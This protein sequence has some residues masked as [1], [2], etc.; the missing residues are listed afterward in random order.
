MIAFAKMLQAMALGAALS[1]AATAAQAADPIK[2]GF[3]TSLTGGNAAFGRAD[4]VTRQ[5][6]AE[7]VNAKGGL[8]GRPVK[9][10]YYDDQSTPANAPSIYTKL[11][12]VDKVDLLTTTG[13]NVTAAAMPSLVQHNRLVMSLFSLAVNDVFKYP[14]YFQIMT[15]GPHGKEEISRGFFEAAMSLNPKPKTIAL[16]GADAEFAL[17]A[18]EG[19]RRQAKRLGL[20]IVYDRTYPPSMVEFSPVIRAV[21]ATNPDLVFVGS[22][23]ADSSGLLRAAIEGGLKTKMFGGGMVGP[24]FATVKAAFGEKL[25]GL[26]NYEL[27]VRAPTM[28]FPG[29]D[30]FIA[31]Y[32]KRAA[33]EKVDALG[34]YV[35]PFIYA[36]MQVMEQAVEK[37]G[38]LDE[39]KLAATMHSTTFP[40]IVGDVKF[41]ADGEWTEGRILMTQFRGLHGNGLEQFDKAGAQVILYPKQFKTGDVAVPFP[42]AQ[43]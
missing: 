12:D 26:V 40:T 5:I 35:P 17:N 23:P 43:K 15:Y 9:L 32:R 30:D 7:R 19:A 25:N 20:K 3:S 8:L 2:I 1:I 10:V 29:T 27:F 21:Q 11:I 16:V 34:L 41:G 14:R 38:S 24:Q 4:L 28:K 37:V 42:P 39:A 22:Y 18:V 13:T 6:W 36:A 33:A 31:E